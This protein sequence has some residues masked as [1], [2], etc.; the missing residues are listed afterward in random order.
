MIVTPA[1]IM[2]TVA[3]REI[4][5]T[6]VVFVG[7]RLPL[8]AFFLAKTTHAPEAVGL[9]ENGLIRDEPARAP[10]VTMCDP[11][12][13]TGAVSCASMRETMSYLQQGRVT[14][15]FIGGA[16]VD[17]YG[18]LNTSRVGSVRLPGSG[19]GADIA[20]AAGRLLIVMSHE[21]RRF[22]ERVDYVTSPGF[23][24]GPGW[25]ESVGLTGG[26]PSAIVTTYGV[27]RFDPLTKKAVLAQIHPEVDIETVREQT[28]FELNVSPDLE[29]TPMP[30]LDELALIRRFDPRGFWTRRG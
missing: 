22:V 23:G 17:Q 28:G 4:R 5:N 10:V 18:N 6:D 3:A 27:F 8:L 24:D 30:T 11:P 13:V 19:G 14:L 25:R 26:G 15:G 21:K 2:V 1:E 16:E 29:I 9:F 7:M 12:N 20:S